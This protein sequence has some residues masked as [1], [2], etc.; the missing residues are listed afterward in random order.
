MA[1]PQQPLAAIALAGAE[2]ERQKW[3]LDAV[4]KMYFICNAM[5]LLH[6]SI[7]ENKAGASSRLL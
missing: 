2:V 1:W 3:C 5:S 7:A 6:Q 4:A